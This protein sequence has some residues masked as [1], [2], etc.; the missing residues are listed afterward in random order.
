VTWCPW[1]CNPTVKLISL[2]TPGTS[3]VKTEV[4]MS[5]HTGCQC[6]AGGFL[7]SS[8]EMMTDQE[9][10][11]WNVHEI[12][13]EM[14]EFCRNRQTC[15]GDGRLVLA[16]SSIGKRCIM[17]V[18]AIFFC[19]CLRKWRRARDFILRRVFIFT[20]QSALAQ[21]SSTCHPSA[22]W[23]RFVALS[24]ELL[25]APSL[26]SVIDNVLSFRQPYHSIAAS[27]PSSFQ[28]TRK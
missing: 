2:L 28:P 21:F 22:N 12:C 20:R 25:R 18:L 8:T 19:V 11:F 4:S 16:R 24:L 17:H 5:L 23:R 15:F 13:V 3:A 10:D 14:A 7:M 6:M 27:P 26:G 1:R 9:P